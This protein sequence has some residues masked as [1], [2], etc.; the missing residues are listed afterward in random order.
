MEATGVVQRCRK[1]IADLLGAESP[2]RIVFTFNGTDSLNLALH[3]LLRAGDHAVPSVIK[4]NSV[5]RPVRELH[6]KLGIEVTHASADAAATIDPAD[7]QRA[8]RPNTKL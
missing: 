4:H 6:R 1:K 7:F 5:L 3:G 2:E 8:L